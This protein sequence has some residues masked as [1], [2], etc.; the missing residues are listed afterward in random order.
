LELA[1]SFRGSIL[2]HHNKKHGS[3]QVDMVLEEAL[4]IL[5]L[6]MKVAWRRLV[7]RQLGGGSQIPLPQ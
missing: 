6:D 2:Y 7:S 4:R 5:H 1:Y 3:R